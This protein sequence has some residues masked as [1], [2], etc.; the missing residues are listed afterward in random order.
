M[1][2]FCSLLTLHS[3][4]HDNFCS[5]AFRILSFY[6]DFSLRETFNHILQRKRIEI[7]S[8][9]ML[10]AQSH[11][12]ETHSFCVFWNSW[13]LNVWKWQYCVTTAEI[14]YSSLLIFLKFKL[15]TG[16][17]H[18]EKVIS[19]LWRC[20]SK[21]DKKLMWNYASFCFFVPWFST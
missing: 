8:I 18:L 20:N 7:W 19:L 13:F 16:I 9:K 2:C 5:L 15:Y 3:K 6:P 1:S 12:K 11:L 14:G 4:S 21:A 10:R 17:E